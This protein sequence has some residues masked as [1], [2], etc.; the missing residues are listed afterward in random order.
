MGHVMVGAGYV[1]G[2]F[3][4][5]RIASYLRDDLQSVNWVTFSWVEKQVL[6]GNKCL[7]GMKLG[8]YH[9]FKTLPITVMIIFLLF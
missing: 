7:I 1:D 6:S 3:R 5:Q 8:S 4:G 9:I 2:G